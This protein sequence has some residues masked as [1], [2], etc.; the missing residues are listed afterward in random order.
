MGKL[1][2]SDSKTKITQV[3]LNP[4]SLPWYPNWAV[5]AYTKD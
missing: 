1:M 4:E 2:E 5:P 3:K